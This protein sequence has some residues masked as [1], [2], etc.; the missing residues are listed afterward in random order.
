MV[1]IFFPQAREVKEGGALRVSLV[2]AHDGPARRCEAR[3]EG[4]LTG[5]YAAQGESHPDPLVEKR[6]HSASRSWRFIL[7]SRRPRARRPPGAL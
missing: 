7:R 2:E 5:L 6:L 4:L 1:R 3:L